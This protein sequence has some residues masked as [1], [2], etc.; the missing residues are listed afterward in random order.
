MQ[1]NSCALRW[2]LVTHCSP[3]TTYK[4]DAPQ[5]TEARCRERFRATL[6][7]RNSTRRWHS[8][9]SVSHSWRAIIVVG[10]SPL[11]NAIRHAAKKM[12]VSKECMHLCGLQEASSAYDNPQCQQEGSELSSTRSH[13]RP[14][15]QFRCMYLLERIYAQSINSGR[16]GKGGR[17]KR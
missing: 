11:H 7:R 4:Q 2:G 3:I 10:Q 15:R 12:S 14:T 5:T 8:G 16:T 6:G 1:H 9:A 17:C 13:V